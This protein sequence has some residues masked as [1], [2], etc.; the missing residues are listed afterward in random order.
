M[1][2]GCGHHVR[3]KQYCAVIKALALGTGR[4]L[5]EFLSCVAEG[6]LAVETVRP[7]NDD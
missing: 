4:L 5:R 2:K 7:G 3:Q 1:Y 6:I